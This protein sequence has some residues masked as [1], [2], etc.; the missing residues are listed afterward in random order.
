MTQ[1]NLFYITYE[2]VL[3]LRAETFGVAAYYDA[4]DT[5]AG[6]KAAR[7]AL[8]AITYPS[9]D[10]APR[11]FRGAAKTF[12]KEPFQVFGALLEANA[13]LTIQKDGKT[14]L[15]LGRAGDVLYGAWQIENEERVDALLVEL[16]A[17]IRRA[18]RREDTP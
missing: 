6:T 18:Q 13:L 17:R 10:D 9:P 11:V 7:N 1:G 15:K 3:G 8:F 2:N 4:I 14:F 16:A 12:G 5:E